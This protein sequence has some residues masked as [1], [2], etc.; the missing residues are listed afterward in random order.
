MKTTLTTIRFAPEEWGQIRAYLRQNRSFES[1]SSL[2]RVALM[3]FIRTRRELPLEPVQVNSKEGRPSFL[4]D[5]DLTESQVREILRHAPFQERKWLIGRILERASLQE[6]LRYLSPEEIRK[7]LPR[8][9]MNTKVKNH[10][11]EAVDL[12]KKS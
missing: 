10:W 2:G 6:V 1:V 7:A 5:Y 3:E 12:W 11:Q 8:L 4:W 9:R